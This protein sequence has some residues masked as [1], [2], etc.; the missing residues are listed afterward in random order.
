MDASA[1]VSSVARRAA[2][3]GPRVGR[4]PTIHVDDIIAAA[5]ELGLEGVTLKQV[6]DHLGVAIATLYRHVAGRDELVRLAAFRLTLQR[7]LP[8]A[9][10][11]HWS[12][13][14]TRY[15]Q[16]LY[17][18]FLAEPQL[19]GEL[20]RGRIGPH[21]EVDVLEQ[22]IAAVHGHGFSE[23][24]S[25]QLFHAIGMVT[26]GAAAGA[27]GKKAADESGAPWKRAVQRTLAERDA[28]ELKRVR[29]VLPAALELDP[30]PWLP[31]LQRLLEGIAAARGEKLPKPTSGK[32]RRAT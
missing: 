9:R 23:A 17:A 2:A 30:I 22:F 3:K 19:I 6:A 24:E 28:H 4:P 7:G 21:A 20:L 14:A 1:A 29:R 16:T 25:A 26:I 15:A 8:E 11:A 32:T 12:E 31:T 13:L 5:L 27:I 10:A 18:S